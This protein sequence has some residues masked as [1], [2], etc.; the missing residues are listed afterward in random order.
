MDPHYAQSQR[1]AP[2]QQLGD[3]DEMQHMW[4]FLDSTLTT[5]TTP[6]GM[7][8]LDATANEVQANATMMAAAQYASGGNG[9]SGAV[10]APPHG[11]TTSAMLH[12]A[13]A[14]QQQTSDELREST[15]NDD[16]NGMYN[17]LGDVFSMFFNIDS[18]EPQQ[19][20]LG[21]SSAAAL[22]YAQAQQMNNA[23]AGSATGAPRYHESGAVDHGNSQKVQLPRSASASSSHSGMDSI[24]PGGLLGYP[25]MSPA[26]MNWLQS[27]A[28]STSSESLSG[29]VSPATLYGTPSALLPG[30]A[31]GNAT[32]DGM[33]ALER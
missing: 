3:A 10:V 1:P 20:H 21:G 4:Q 2:S 32:V 12:P 19:H 14:R 5:G 15:L 9:S 27:L 30:S 6:N 29:L 7:P 28:K 17:E 26:T 8:P 16:E 23:S 11:T 24:S 13:A 25:S 18:D 33:D 22:A 31:G